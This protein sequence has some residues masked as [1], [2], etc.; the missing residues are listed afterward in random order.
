MQ[1]T[2][3][4]ICRSKVRSVLSNI[5]NNDLYL[6]LGED[7]YRNLRTGKEGE[8]KPKLAAAI[9]NLNVPMTVMIGDNIVIES[10]I[11][12]LQLKAEPTI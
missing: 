6:H 4:P 2:Q 9:F 5:Q 8:I 10:L 3:T 12:K 11:K 7:N 1:K